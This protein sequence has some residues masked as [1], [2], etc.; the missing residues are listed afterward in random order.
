MTDEPIDHTAKVLREIQAML[1]EHGK[2]FQRIDEKLD[3][4]LTRQDRQYYRMDRVTLESAD[5]SSELLRLDASVR[6][7][8][9]RVEIVEGRTP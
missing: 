7:L 8:A 2:M 5:A 4:V 1:A 6:A 9:A 3:E